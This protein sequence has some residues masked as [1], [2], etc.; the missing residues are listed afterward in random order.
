VSH[1]EVGIVGLGAMGSM[2]ALELARRGRKVIGFDRFH[3]PHAFGSSHGKSRI[4]REA[5][6]EHPQYVP[7]VRHAW[8]KWLALER[9]SGRTLLTPT[10]G[11]MIGPPES[12]LVA[13]ARRSALEHGLPF[14]QLSA[15]RVRLRFPMFELGE[16]E[17]GIYEER[18]G[19]LFP[20]AAIEAALDLA[21]QAGAELMFDEPVT[22]WNAGEAITVRSG[23]RR[24]SVDRLILSAGAWMAG[25]L[26]RTPL[27]LSTARQTLFW[28]AP[29]GDPSLVAPARMPIF[30]WEWAPGE[31]FYGFPDF[32]DGVKV[33]IH[34]Q[35]EPAAPDHLRRTVYPGEADRLR[36]V[37]AIRAP[38]F[39]G[40]LQ[41]SAACLY[42]NTEDG[43]FIID[44]H[45]D[46]ARVVL[47][48]PCSGHGFKF[49][50]AIGEV[51]ADLVEGKPPRFDLNPFRLSRES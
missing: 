24:A 25:D 1:Y 17:V 29:L 3:P 7:I 19:V 47:A 12:T 10:G 39:N 15:E 21:A 41:E 20:E 14:E 16:H 38:S 28:F 32:G 36:E 40:P 9:D 50:P 2:A 22:M 11:L 49:A 51:L 27:G 44:R 8:D 34:H 5:Y 13:G 48:S 26:P 18:A 42:T 45:P 6:F 46:D 30:I 33:A 4:I 23:V 35:G 37:L 31:M 43:D